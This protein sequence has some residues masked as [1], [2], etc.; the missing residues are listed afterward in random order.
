MSS[1]TRERHRNTEEVLGSTAS[2]GPG[3][4][5]WGEVGWGGGGGKD[6]GLGEE[7]GGESGGKEKWEIETRSYRRRRRETDRQTETDRQRH[8]ERQR[9]TE[10]GR[11]RRPDTQVLSGGV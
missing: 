11:R 5:S 3:T 4:L 8:T 6:G 9:E 10:R 7:N 1:G 2:W